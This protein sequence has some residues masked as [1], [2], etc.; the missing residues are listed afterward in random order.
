MKRNII[1]LLTLSASLLTGG[2]LLGQNKPAA[3]PAAAQKPQKLVRMATLNTVEAN[4][5]FQANV[6]LIQ[7]QRNAV[8]ELNGRVEKETDPKKKQ[9]LKTQFDQALA[10]LNENNALMEK[11]YNF[12]LNRNYTLEIERAHVYMLVTEEEAAAFEKEQKAQADK[13]AKKK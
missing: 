12:S 6:Q 3:A 1:G 5:E 8:V 13:A 11:T 2:Y 7:A 4:R 10:K 9:E